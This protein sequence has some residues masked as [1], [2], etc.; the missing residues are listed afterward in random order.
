MQVENTFPATKRT[1]S[2]NYDGYEEVYHLI[3]LPA[4]VQLSDELVKLLSLPMESVVEFLE[5]I[6]RTTS[7]LYGMCLNIPVSSLVPGRI[8]MRSWMDITVLAKVNAPA[9]NDPS[10]TCP[11]DMCAR[12]IC[13]APAWLIACLTGVLPASRI[14]WLF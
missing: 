7:L 14:L 3:I 12:Y 6:V 10:Y 13:Q 2:T 5:D 4:E 8:L 1:K 9:A 11:E